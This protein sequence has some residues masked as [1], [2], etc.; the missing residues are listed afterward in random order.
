M[1]HPLQFQSPEAHRF[2]DDDRFAA[3]ETTIGID[4]IDDRSE[5]LLLQLRRADVVEQ[6]I[7]EF[8]VELDLS[9]IRR[10][11][12]LQQV[13]A[14]LVNHAIERGRGDLQAIEDS[15]PRQRLDFP[16]VKRTIGEQG[17][18]NDS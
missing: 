15:M 5:G 7:D 6:V 16:V 17:E 13:I 4:D 12:T 9:D 11:R 3:I 8:P 14:E 18:G 10:P 2:G 1:G